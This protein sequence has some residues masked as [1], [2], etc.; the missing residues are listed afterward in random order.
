MRVKIWMTGILILAIGQKLLAQAQISA[1]GVIYV[2]TYKAIA[3]AEEQRSG[4][5]A[6][7]TLAQG[8]HESEA[9]TSELCKAS[10]NHFGIKCRDDWK[11]PVVYHDD[12][13]RHECFRSYACAAD[14]YRDH[15]DFLRSGSRYAFLFQLDP[16][17]YEGWAYGLRKAGYA[18]NVR[19]SQ[20]LIKFIKDYNL[21]QYTLIAMGKLK[22]EDEVALTMPGVPQVAA[23]APSAGVNGT[24]AAVAVQNGAGTGVASGGQA[25]SVDQA[26]APEVAYPG[27]EFTINRTKVIYVRGGVSLLS[28][29]NQYDIP[30]GRLLEFNDMQQED[31]LVKGQLL[32]LQ[33]KRRTGSIP[34]HVVQAGEN[35]YDIAQAEGIRFEDMLEMNQLTPGV[36]PA[37]GERIYLQG[38]APSRPRLADNQ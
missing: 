25:A 1:N 28:I 11:G 16:T 5:P 36:Q 17:D 6:A 12:D 33:R 9:G 35:L 31:V 19:Y 15:S 34:Y 30:L 3:I 13:A 14:S 27:G 8:L 21:Q 24:A 18:T 29:A 38:S 20:I 2:N 26:A 32:F 22:P 10:N 4:V 7:I 37:A 23:I